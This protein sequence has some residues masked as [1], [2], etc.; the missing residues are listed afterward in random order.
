MSVWYEISMLPPPRCLMISKSLKLR[1]YFK[2]RKFC[3]T[4]NNDKVDSVETEH[5]VIADLLL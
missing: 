5:I 2:A 4:K 3:I 1:R